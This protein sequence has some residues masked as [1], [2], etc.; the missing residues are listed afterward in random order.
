MLSHEEHF[1]LRDTLKEG[2]ALAIAFCLA[3]LNLPMFGMI[4]LYQFVVSCHPL[5]SAS[6][7]CSVVQQTYKMVTIS[8]NGSITDEFNPWSQVIGSKSWW[9]YHLHLLCVPP[10]FSWVNARNTSLTQS[11]VHSRAPESEVTPHVLSSSHVL[12]DQKVTVTRIPRDYTQ[13]ELPRFRT[14]YPITLKDQ[15]C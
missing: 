5:L 10:G 14:S 9:R 11:P 6:L 8:E 1:G 15:V 3:L 7:A 13:C 4:L 12:V 2:A